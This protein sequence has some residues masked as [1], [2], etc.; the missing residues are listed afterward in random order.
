VSTRL[1]IADPSGRWFDFKLR[2]LCYVCSQLAFSNRVSTLVGGNIFTTGMNWAVAFDLPNHT[3]RN[4]HPKEMSPS[5]LRRQRREL[6]RR[7]ET[8]MDS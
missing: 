8:A 1:I 3:L 2:L 5:L 4:P 7:L 6:Y